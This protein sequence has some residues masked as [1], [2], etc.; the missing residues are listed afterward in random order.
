MILPWQPA[1]YPFICL[2]DD[3]YLHPSIPR[4][5][6]LSQH[7]SN[8][9]PS[10]HS[11]LHQGNI[12]ALRVGGSTAGGHRRCASP[13][14]VLS[15]CWAGSEKNRS[16]CRGKHCYSLFFFISTEC[17]S[18]RYLLPCIFL[19]WMCVCMYVCI[20]LWVCAAIFP[21]LV[22]LSVPTVLCAYLGNRFPIHIASH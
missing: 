12:E 21:S 3:Q 5:I 15:S 9:I 19:R 4:F 20:C 16:D 2:F 14:N 6:C 8:H 10:L 17:E 1:G 22:C 11:T 13:G 7:Y 18:E